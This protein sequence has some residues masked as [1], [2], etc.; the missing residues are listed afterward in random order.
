MESLDKAQKELQS[1]PEVIDLLA[2]L[3]IATKQDSIMTIASK[4]G[5]KINS[6]DDTVNKDLWK[7]TTSTGEK[8]EVKFQTDKF[9]IVVNGKTINT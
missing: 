3:E 5:Y 9:L 6:W 8:G 1:D 2:Q 7:F 4:N